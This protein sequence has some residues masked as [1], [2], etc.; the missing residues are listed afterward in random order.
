MI[1]LRAATKDDVETI[2]QI[3]S[4][5]R[6]EYIPYAKSFHT[7]DEYRNWVFGNLLLTHDVVIAQFEG[8]DVG[9]LATTVDDQYAWINQ[10]YLAPGFLGQGI[11]K[12]LLDYAFKVLPR[13]IRLWT[14]QENIR[15]IKFY[16]KNG[17]YSVNYTDG[18]GSEE[19]SPYVL[20]ECT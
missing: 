3:L 17:F 2:V 8:V 14:F 19:K 10:L 1:E 20:Y 6:A 18:E 4:K 5:S 12:Y 13:P 7:R 11:G 16:E 9:V 15:A